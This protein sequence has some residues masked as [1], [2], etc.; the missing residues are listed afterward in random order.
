MCAC[1]DGLST[2]DCVCV[3]VCVCDLTT[4]AHVRLCMCVCMRTKKVMSVVPGGSVDAVFCSAVRS[5]CAAT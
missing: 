2:S 3:C 5:S 4:R 1:F